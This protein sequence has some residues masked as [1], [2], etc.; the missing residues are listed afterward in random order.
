MDKCFC[1]LNGY[2]VKDATA[3]KD[4]ETLNDNLSST[5]V[6]LN[7]VAKEVVDIN[8]EILNE[9]ENVIKH[10]NFFLGA[11]FESLEPN[12]TV[13]CVSLD[14]ANWTKLNLPFSFNE[15]DVSIQYNKINKKF[16]ACLPSVEDNVDFIIY[17]SI[18]LINW[19]EH[20]INANHTTTPTGFK[21]AP[22]LYID[23]TGKMYVVLAG[24]YSNTETDLRGV[25]INGFDQFITTCDNDNFEFTNVRKL[26]LYGDGLSPNR[27]HI[28]G[29]LCKIDGSFY[30]TVK[31]EYQHTTEIFKSTDLQSFTLI[32]SN[33]TKSPI[34]IEGGQL[35]PTES[36]VYFIADMYAD[37]RYLS[38]RVNKN[39]LS[40]FTEPFIQCNTLKGFRHGSVIYV[41][42]DNAKNVISRVDGFSFKETNEQ[43]TYD[44]KQ[45]VLRYTDNNYYI[46]GK[47]GVIKDYLYLCF[48]DTTVEVSNPFNLD[49]MD[50]YFATSVGKKLTITKIDGYT[51]PTPV[52]I[53]N[54]EGVNERLIRIP[55]K[56]LKRNC[57]PNYE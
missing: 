57:K 52:V 18:D 37:D 33:V 41:N 49:Y 9:K 44:S 7:D 35:I 34:F 56:Y 5:N 8:D 10:P 55:L 3:R 23:E 53:T 40:N 43:I 45:F 42:D 19:N 15:R 6:R 30:L 13:W 21:W 38:T 16:Y 36:D 47:I 11:F 28:D 17:D 31:D 51:L 48:V 4:I 24:R 1:H 2:A 22:D 39:S 12:K 20:K 50:M 54:T 29:S 26:N 32:N 25:S 46:D 14:C 27:N